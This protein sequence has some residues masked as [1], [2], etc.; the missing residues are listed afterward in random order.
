[1]MSSDLYFRDKIPVAVLGASQQIGQMMIQ[2]IA[3]H[4]WFELIALYDSASF[5]GKQFGEGVQWL[6]SAPIPAVVAKME[7]QS[8]ESAPPCA[9]VFSALSSNEGVEK[10]RYFAHAGST[11]I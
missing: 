1:M 9:I 7:I 4:P 3:A 11:V 2:L 5:V 8:F 10:E 6:L